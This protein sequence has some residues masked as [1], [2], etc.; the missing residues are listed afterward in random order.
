MASQLIDVQLK[1]P[2]G[3]KSPIVTGSRRLT[4]LNIAKLLWGGLNAGKAYGLS[5]SSSY[6][7]VQTSVVAAYNTAVVAAVQSADTLSIAGT[8]LTATK[9]RSTAT[10]TCSTALA[11]QTVTVNGTVFTAVSGAA[12]LGDATFSIDTG[13]TETA[14]S[15][16]AQVNAYGGPLIAGIVSAYSASGV[17]TFFADTP[18]TAGDSLTLA[19]S[20]AGTLLTSGATFT[21]G[22]AIANNQFDFTTNALC[23]D[24]L[25]Y[26]INNSTTT[27]IKQVTAVSNGVDTVTV[28]AKVGGL[29]G[30]TITF[31]SSNGTRINVG[32]AGVLENGSASAV[33]RWS[34]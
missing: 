25:A 5:G 23:A 14:T 10:V 20:D 6:L 28:T 17:V 11:A 29:A 9:Q 19:S 31:T 7:Q 27:A 26:A 15:L 22:A 12:T 4:L 32:S 1:L 3:V 21:G 8:A 24:S 13:D 30:N 18:G 34:L 33:T 2:G 16:A